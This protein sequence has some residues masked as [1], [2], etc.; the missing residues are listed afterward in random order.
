MSL[1]AWSNSSFRIIGELWGEFFGLEED[2][3]EA[4]SFDVGEMLI[5]TEKKNKIDEWI[6]IS[7]NGRTYAHAVKKKK[8]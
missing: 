2:T 7:I 6:N 8:T 4:V 5:V 1:S 3:R